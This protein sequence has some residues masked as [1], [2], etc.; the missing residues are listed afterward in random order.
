M[1]PKD[2]PNLIAWYRTSAG[3]YSAGRLRD[4]S[5][6]GFHWPL[7]AGA[8]VFT[9]RAGV[10]CMDLDGN[11]FF[12]QPNILPGDVTIVTTVRPNLAASDAR[13]DWL[14]ARS[15]TYGANDHGAHAPTDIWAASGIVISS[16][17]ANLYTQDYQSVSAI[18]P[19]AK[20][21]WHVTVH[22]LNAAGQRKVAADNGAPVI[23]TE[24]NGR[25][26]ILALEAMRLGYRSSGITTNAGANYLALAEVLILSGD[27]TLDDPVL[28]R[29][30]VADRMAQ[31][32]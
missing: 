16:T 23:A 1:N 22:T 20:N 25:R 17:E 31:L 32:A 9:N 18:M 14:W 19:L 7:V 2:L 21:A 5:D 24:S 27:M 13:F 15:R 26:A 11:Q 28:L 10:D 4:L 29:G 30:L 8:P 12:E 6:R 3:G